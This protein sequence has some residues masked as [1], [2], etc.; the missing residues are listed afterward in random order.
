ML[1][2]ALGEEAGVEEVLELIQA[3]VLEDNQQFSITTGTF[4]EYK[5]QNLKHARLQFGCPVLRCLIR[6]QQKE[7][8]QRDRESRHGSTFAGSGD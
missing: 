7:G 3:H 5:W 2:I 8:M 4:G 6:L 1:T